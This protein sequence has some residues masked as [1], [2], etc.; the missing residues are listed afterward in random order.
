M[1][2]GIATTPFGGGS[3][4]AR[5][6]LRRNQVFKEQTRRRV[7]A[8]STTAASADKWRILRD[9]TEAKAAYDL[10][11]RSIAVLEAL[12]SFH[13]ERQLDGSKPLIVFPSNQQLSLRTRGMSPATIRRHLAALVAAGLIFRRDSPNGKRY[14]RRDANGAPQDMFGF[15]LAP[16]ALTAETIAAEAETVRAEERG[17]QALRSEVTLHLRDIA[18]LLQAALNEKRAGDWEGFEA[19]LQALSGRVA[20]H[21]CLADLT[22]RRNRLLR[23]RADVEK[24]YLEALSSCVS[25]NEMSAC[26]HQFEHHIQNPESDQTHE[27]AL[28]RKEDVYAAKDTEDTGQARAEH[29]TQTETSGQETVS[30]PRIL[31]ACPQIADYSR[32]GIRNW[33]DFLGAVAL[34]RTML[35]ISPTAWNAASA[36]MGEAQAA[37]A[38]AAMLERAEHIRSPGSYLRALARKTGT[39]RFAGLAMM[40]ALERQREGRDHPGS[41]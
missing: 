28:E 14:C 29:R 34:V 5:Q 35:K 20:R 4:D 32:N 40:R 36:V 16:L 6:I 39:G 21:A 12:L 27:S 30:L 8:S 19:R 2:E 10:S 13:P 17:R 7:E 37:I 1:N 38:I 33:S 25:S 23:L 11:D 9:L 24:T 18:K 15:D 31:N 3:I 22:E 26:V 41:V